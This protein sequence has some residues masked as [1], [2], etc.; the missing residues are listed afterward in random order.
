MAFV[1][2]ELVI[3]NHFH[4]TV[5]RVVQIEKSLDSLSGFIT[6]HDK[7]FPPVFQYRVMFP[8]IQRAES[9]DS[10]RPEGVIQAE[11]IQREFFALILRASGEGEPHDKHT[12]N[13]LIN[14]PHDNYF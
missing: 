14:H 4:V 12:Y 8:V 10:L 11:I 6:V 5:F 1:R 3:L 13:K 7:L 9:R 2:A